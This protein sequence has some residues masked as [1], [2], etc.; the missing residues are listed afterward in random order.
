MIII[1]PEMPDLSI[2]THNKIRALENL[3]LAFGECRHVIWM[4]TKV[5]T[6]LIDKN[7]L[8]S[9]A[10]RVLI[11]LRSFSTE[12]RGI[13]KFF[14]FHL[15]IDFNTGKRLDTEDGRILH[16]GYSHI[17]DSMSLK[18]SILLTENLRDSEIFK[19]GG[20]IFLFSNK[21]YRFYSVSLEQLPGGGNT[22]FDLFNHLEASGSFFLC[23]IDSD[24]KHPA[25][26]RGDTAKRF[27]S[28]TAGYEQKRF[29]KILDCHEVENIIPF[30]VVQEVSNGAIENSLMYKLGRVSSDRA[31]P[32]HKLGLS[33]SQAMDQDEKYQS[34]HWEAY[35]RY[36]CSNKD[37]WIVPPLGENL[38]SNCLNF[39]NKESISKLHEKLS[40]DLDGIW[41][42]LSKS[43]ASWGISMKRRIN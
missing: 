26:P 30:S 6:D 4:P 13:E 22:T 38:L 7:I 3:L 21:L 37:P 32:D 39:M 31:H 14:A 35:Y 25:G 29:L 42:D 36:K 43:I 28:T 11:E 41:M 9:Y 33:L 27:S 8:G 10:Q 12:S 18:K 16:V 15:K 17:V 20:E 40:P 24:L 5:A 2:D 1:I 23:V 19:L 34:K